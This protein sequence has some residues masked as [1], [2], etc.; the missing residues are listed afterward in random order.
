MPYLKQYEVKLQN[1]SEISKA[2][3]IKSSCFLHLLQ[4]NISNLIGHFLDQFKLPITNFLF[5]E[6]FVI[7]FRWRTRV[8]RATWRPCACLVLRVG[9][10]AAFCVATASNLGTAP[11]SS[12]APCTPTTSSQ[13]CPAVRIDLRYFSVI[14]NYTS[15]AYWTKLCLVKY[16]FY[17]VKKYTV[18]TGGGD[19]P[20]KPMSHLALLYWSSVEAFSYETCIPTM[21]LLLS[22]EY[23]FYLTYFSSMTHRKNKCFQF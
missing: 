3:V 22:K 12:S 18:W 4:C 20:R 16:I 5:F 8:K 10:A 11:T 14:S 17:T 1:L 23:T 7:I 2:T 9:P 21:Y 15:F 6:P 19:F 13:Q